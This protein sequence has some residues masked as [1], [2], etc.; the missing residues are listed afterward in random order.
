MV[1]L[2]LAPARPHE[3]GRREQCRRVP[4]A[5]PHLP[6]PRVRHHDQGVER[7]IGSSQ[8]S[9]DLRRRSLGATFDLGGAGGTILGVLVDQLAPLRRMESAHHR[10]GVTRQMREE[11][12]PRPARKPARRLH[13]LIVQTRRSPVHHVMGRGDAASD[14]IDLMQCLVVTHPPI[15]R[16]R[17]VRVHSSTV[18]VAGV[19]AIGRPPRRLQSRGVGDA[20]S[21]RDD[22]VSG[23]IGGSLQRERLAAGGVGFGDPS[24][25]VVG[26]ALPAE[27]HGAAVHGRD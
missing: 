15:T 3:L 16:A 17:P 24:I 6:R 21:D 26:G 2:D 9:N 8:V 11:M 22:L 18:R 13:A 14:E 19:V 7:V 1:N 4:A 12:A 10:V 5:S 23:E 27:Q 20:L 25:R